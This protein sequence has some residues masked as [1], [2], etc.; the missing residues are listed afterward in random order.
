MLDNAYVLY[1]QP[2]NDFT[3]YDIAARSLTG[4]HV[5]GGAVCG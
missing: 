2:T 5:A 4:G 3:G 1:A